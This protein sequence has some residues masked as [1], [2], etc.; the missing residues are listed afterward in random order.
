MPLGSSRATLLVVLLLV[1]P[2]VPGRTGKPLPIDQHQPRRTLQHDRQITKRASSRKLLAPA[3]PASSPAPLCVA[4]VNFGA[5]GIGDITKPDFIGSF[6][7]VLLQDGP[8]QV[9][10]PSVQAT[11]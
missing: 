3:P 6:S 2:A 8:L 7:I 4:A 11:K 5:A 10:A 1:L 9:R